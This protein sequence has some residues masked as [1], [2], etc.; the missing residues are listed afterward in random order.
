MLQK[1][2]TLLPLIANHYPVVLHWDDRICWQLH[3]L[4]FREII[5]SLWLEIWLEVNTTHFHVQID[6]DRCS[7]KS[8]NSCPFSLMSELKIFESFIYFF[9]III[10][11]D[12]LIFLLFICGCSCLQLDGIMSFTIHTIYFCKP[13]QK[14][15]KVPWLCIITNLVPLKTART[16]GYRREVY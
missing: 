14:L 11:S 3:C 13:K 16:F 12:I 15:A 6:Y 8:W 7:D 1:N 5:A 4:F 10:K 2:A 9:I